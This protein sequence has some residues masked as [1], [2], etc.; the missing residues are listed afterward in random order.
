M[1]KVLIAAAAMSMMLSSPVLAQAQLRARIGST[2][3]DSS[4]TIFVIDA[5]RVEASAVPAMEL[6]DIAYVASF[7]ARLA[8][9][10]FGV[11]NG[12]SLVRIITRRSAPEF[13]APACESSS[14]VSFEFQTDT[15]ARYLPI[16]APIL[17][18]LGSGRAARSSPTALVVQF[19]VSA[20]GVM[21]PRTLKILHAEST[22]DGAA[23][24]A[25]ASAW[26][27]APALK[28]GCRVAQLVQTEVRPR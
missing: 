28:D 27:F 12:K 16:E 17:Q 19:V 7:D 5:K 9:A 6:G 18:P 14:Q 15:A 4:N 21:N 8:Q 1:L 24:R 20:D 26:Q 2:I 25:V 22:D 3:K 23:V 11:T 13:S 10:L